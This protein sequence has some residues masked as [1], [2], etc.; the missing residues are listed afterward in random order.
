MIRSLFVL[1]ILV[2]GWGSSRACT[3]AIV[4]G[5]F[6][7]D[8]RPLLFKHRDTGF[9]QNKLMYFSDGKYDYIA[10]VNSGDKEGNE[11]W[12]GFNSAGFAIMN[13]E[14][15][16]LNVGD[17]TQLKDQEGVFMKKVLQECATLSDFEIF[18]DQ[19]VT[20]RGV[21]A[22]F[23]VID[24]RGGAAY[25]ETGNFKWEKFDVNDP[26]QAPFGY[27]IRTNFAFGGNKDRG[28][29]YIR[30]QNADNLFFQAAAENN[31][32][33]K[34]IIQKVSRCLQHSLTGIDLNRFG[35][36]TGFVSLE[37]YI[38]RYSS[39]STTVVQGVLPGENPEF[40][41]FWTVLG[42]QLCTVA[43]PV[44]LN[45]NKSIPVIMSADETGYAPICDM[46]LQLKEYCY[47]VQ[48]G[49]GKKYLKLAAL[50]NSEKTGLLQKILPLEN[51]IIKKAES[52]QNQ[53]YIKGP[54]PDGIMAYYNWIDN[55]VAEYYK[56][57]LK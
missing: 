19:Y 35:S 11:V 28:F 47:P 40:T 20:P 42:W 44:W 14:A 17:T 16:N 13:S 4:S 37:D 53:L 22:N 8:G 36:P 29:G 38:P 51:K 57:L 32:S 1:L 26:A 2:I 10:T 43:I 6:T 52:L 27:L 50:I 41:T 31:L 21:R 33:F 7:V 3:T 23:G 30:Y 9:L 12:A 55:T 46:A 39:A 18:L 5:K 45:S 15:Y 49:S 24:A 48:R 25:Y 34:F 54:D 56:N